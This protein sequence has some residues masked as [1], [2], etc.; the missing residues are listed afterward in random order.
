MLKVDERFLYILLTLSQE[1]NIKTGRFSM[2]Y[3]DEVVV[4]HTNEHEY[5]AFVGNK[6]SEALQDRIILVQVPY[7][8]RISDEVRIYDKLLRQSN[9]RDVHIAP[10]TLATAATF[11]VLSRLEES[12]KAGMSLMKKLKLYDGESVDGFTPKDV[13]ELRAEAIREGMDGI[14]PRYVINRLSSA[15]VKD[16]ITCINAIDALRSLRDGLGQHT[17]I[18][19][20][21]QEHLLN[22]ISEARREYDELAKREVQRAFVY[23]FDESAKTLLDNYLDNVE[24][25]CNKSKIK[26]PI[27]EEEM[28][29]DEK[30]MRSIEEQV[31]VAENGK[32]A[33]RE[34]ILIRISS[35][36]RRGQTFDYSSHERLREAIEKKLF[37]D[38]RDVVKITTS[39]KTPD[40]DQLRRINDVVDRLIASQGYCPVC[41]NELLRYVGSLLSR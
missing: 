1:Q 38:L 20:E 28:E 22:L 32:R 11:A 5:R 16:G 25:F 4:S 33:F 29:P 37:A 31:G 23:A 17:S 36:A 24:A 41:A 8:L 14:S 9:L 26:D 7:N 15:L 21:Q 19:R 13:R 10:H 34:E 2:I 30:L 6:K 18:G 3:A 40:A 12:K 35:L 27:T 39:S